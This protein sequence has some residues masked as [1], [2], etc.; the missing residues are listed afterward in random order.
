M[1]HDI[2]NALSVVDARDNAPVVIA[3]SS[4]NSNGF[5]F[6]KSLEKLPV[7]KIYVRDPFD[8]WFQRG[9][10]PEINTPDLLSA[11][12]RSALRALRPRRVVTMGASMGGYAALL[13]GYLLRA[14]SVF[15]M[16]PQT[17]I[18]PRL[19][20][21]PTENYAGTAYFDLHPLLRAKNR[22]RPTAHI[23]F[24]SDDIVDIWN[25]CRLAPQTADSS[26]PVAGRDHLAS[27]LVAANGDLLR[28]IAGLC[29]GQ[30]VSLTAALDR[31]CEQPRIRAIV[32]R[33]VR[34]LY[35][36]EPDLEPEEWAERLRRL[37]PEWSV[38]Y[39]V[40]CMLARRKRDLV[41]AEK[42]AGQ[43]VEFAPQSITLQTIHAD[44][45]LQLGREAEAAAAY[46]RCLV[47]RPKHYAALCALG[48]LLARAGKT[49]EALLRLNTAINI[50]PR[51]ARAHTLKAAIG[52][53]EAPRMSGE[54]KPEDM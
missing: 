35:L 44:I 16:S 14:D 51:L 45:L 42:A 20:H 1:N 3:F 7:S 48:G 38:P 11:H 50:R 17:I 23:L 36:D 32:D 30:E 21:T 47:I 49:E 22:H 28:M 10:S 9:I 27:N 25:A 5:S 33:L 31:R 12:L 37:E 53:G 40:I 34:A 26:Y 52:R 2:E 8:T 15:A 6:Y 4:V 29:E 24:G 41:R 39:N 18:D 54:D 43:A 19:P 46:A 13:F